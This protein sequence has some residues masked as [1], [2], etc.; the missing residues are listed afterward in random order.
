M[1][2][3]SK[4]TDINDKRIRKHQ[5][6]YKVH[7]A[8]GGHS[9]S[10]DSNAYQDKYRTED[11]VKIFCVGCPQCGHYH[12]IYDVTPSDPIMKHRGVHIYGPYKTENITGGW[13]RG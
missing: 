1:A 4:M 9:F 3:G 6:W 2:Y 5:R 8:C 12:W 7:C 10:R 13:E 11:E